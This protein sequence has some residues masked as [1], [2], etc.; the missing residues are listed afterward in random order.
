MSN[1]STKPCGKPNKVYIY[2]NH[3]TAK[4][5]HGK[6]QR[7]KKFTPQKKNQHPKKSVSTI[8]E[9]TNHLTAKTNAFLR[10]P[11]HQGFAICSF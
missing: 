11:L 10:M 1:L 2:E 4:Q 8:W 3:L 6:Q 5:M 7:K 9:I